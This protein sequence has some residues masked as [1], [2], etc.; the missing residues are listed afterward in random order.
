MSASSCISEWSVLGPLMSSARSRYSP[1]VP[2]FRGTL[3]AAALSRSSMVGAILTLR[4]A[5]HWSS[6]SRSCFSVAASWVSRSAINFRLLSPANLFRDS[7]PVFSRATACWIEVLCILVGLRTFGR[8]RRGEARDADLEIAGDAL[9]GRAVHHR[10]QGRN[11]VITQVGQIKGDGG[12]G[13]GIAVKLSLIDLPQVVVGGVDVRVGPVGEGD[14]GNADGGVVE[15]HMVARIKVR[16]HLRPVRFA[17]TKTGKNRPRVRRRVV[18]LNSGE[19]G[20][21]AL[22]KTGEDVLDHIVQETPA[23]V[24]RAA[25]VLDAAA[26]RLLRSYH[27]LVDVRD[28]LLPLLRVL[29]EVLQFSVDFVGPPEANVALGAGKP[30]VGDHRGEGAGDLNAGTF[31]MFNVGGSF[32]YLSGDDPRH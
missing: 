13:D 25:D 2:R 1:R 27:I 19:V 14:G 22:H 30:A 32:A 9:L 18:V 11:S 6:R 20:I 7:S 10:G 3:V 31:G 5:A 21:V 24:R 8:G 16:H 26:E 28:D 29:R 12:H 23:R 4:V 15:N 17:R